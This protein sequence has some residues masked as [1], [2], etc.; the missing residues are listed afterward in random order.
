MTL[1]KIYAIAGGI[2]GLLIG[3]V[4]GFFTAASVFG[5]LFLYFG[6][7]FVEMLLLVLAV[8]ILGFTALG[9]FIGYSRGRRIEQKELLVIEGERKKAYI[10][11][12]SSFILLLFGITFLAFQYNEQRIDRQQLEE[13]KQY[14]SQLFENIH[15]ITSAQSELADDS[16]GFNININ[17]D[18]KRSGEY[19]LQLTVADTLY[20]STLFSYKE[21]LDLQEGKKKRDVFIDYVEL[22]SSYRKINM[23]NTETSFGIKEDFVVR[24]IL[25]PILNDFELSGV[26]S[27]GL[28]YLES[29]IASLVTSKTL[30]LPISFI[31]DG[32][33][34]KVITQ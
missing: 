4:A 3:S 32:S 7:L 23:R 9:I 26:G 1:R 33:E 21:S 18:G 25:E 28:T 34:Y 19:I 17:L 27:D 2:L 20:D 5:A 11:L 6:L 13:R 10:V 24:I 30:N 8:S 12:L 14:A 22:M 29:G 15:R 31:F 16:S